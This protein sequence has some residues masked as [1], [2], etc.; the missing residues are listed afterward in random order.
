MNEEKEREISLKPTCWDDGR[1]L[2]QSTVDGAVLNKIDG[3]D[4]QLYPF[5]GDR[6]GLGQ[7]NDP[8]DDD[9]PENK[10]ERD[11]VDK[12][13]KTTWSCRIVVRV[14][15]GMKLC[16]RNHDQIS[17]EGNCPWRGR[18]HRQLRREEV[19]PLLPVPT[20]IGT[21]SWQVWKSQSRVD[22]WWVGLKRLNSPNRNTDNH[23]VRDY[24]DS[25]MIKLLSRQR[26][27]PPGC[28]EFQCR[29][30]EAETS[31]PGEIDSFA[32]FPLPCY[33][34]VTFLAFRMSYPRRESE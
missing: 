21:K 18:M 11:A 19:S 7:N 28:G 12:T 29:C 4:V 13:K 27:P 2:R 33:I 5:G 20:R 15:E 30:G 23:N 6:G 16:S 14:R 17:C 1:V 24:Y 3:A 32:R 10:A 8:I 25:K 31:I 26:I 22:Y 34:V 9:C